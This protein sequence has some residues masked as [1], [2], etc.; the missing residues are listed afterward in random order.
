[1]AKGSLKKSALMTFVDRL[2]EGMGM[3]VANLMR[4]AELISDFKQ[5]AVDQTSDH[6]RR[7]DLAEVSNEV[8]NML[9]PGLRKKGCDIQRHLTPNLKCDSFPGR[10][11]QILTN[12]V[13]NAIIH[14]YDSQPPGVVE[15][16]TRAVGDDDV[17]LVVV[18]HGAGMNALVRDRIFDPFFTTKMGHGGTGLGMNI[19]HSI[20][21]R[22]LGGRITVQ[23]SPGMGT[24]VSVVIPRVTQEL[25][26]HGVVDL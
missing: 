3:S 2:E 17:E 20:V 23:S 25:H 19:V 9:Q 8:L 10:Y 13:M 1:L 12:L 21:T 24:T 5:V 16:H 26:G 6:R 22:V 15:V 7:F 4:S 18:D 11:G 14:G